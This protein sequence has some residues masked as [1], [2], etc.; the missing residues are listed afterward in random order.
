MR[1]KNYVSLAREIPAGLP[2]RGR[3]DS[4]WRRRPSSSL[5]SRPL[6][7]SHTAP[8][9]KRRRGRAAGNIGAG[10]LRREADAH[11]QPAALRARAEHV[12]QQRQLRG[13][14][15]VPIFFYI[16]FSKK[17]KK[18][19]LHAELL[20][21][22]QS[23]MGVSLPLGRSSRGIGG[24]SRSAAPPI[25]GSAGV[26]PPSA[27]APPQQGDGSAYICMHMHMHMHMHII[28]YTCKC[29]YI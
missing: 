29:T 8:S 10:L 15:R 4:V 1:A 16:Y 19:A 3:H 17:K 14:Q 2:S 11:A 18:C 9:C 7:P 25:Y 24:A 28:I 22:A 12:C 27:H 23:M 26:S 13:D 21:T 20:T 5:E 6:L